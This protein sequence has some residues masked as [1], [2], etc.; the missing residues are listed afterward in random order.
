[1]IHRWLFLF[2]RSLNET[3]RLLLLLLL[4]VAVISDRTLRA[5]KDLLLVRIVLTQIVIH[6]G[7]G[8]LDSLVLGIA[9]WIKL[10]VSKLL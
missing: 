6:L 1:M 4:S 7:E 8:A 3:L 2:D 10:L 5:L 9:M